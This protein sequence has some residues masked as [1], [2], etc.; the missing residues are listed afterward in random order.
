MRLCEELFNGAIINAPPDG[1]PESIEYGLDISRLS[2]VAESGESTWDRCKLGYD[3][4]SAEFWCD[5][6][7]LLGCALKNLLI[8]NN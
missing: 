2:V 3:T 4:V 7:L 5:D 1:S 8:Q 6:K